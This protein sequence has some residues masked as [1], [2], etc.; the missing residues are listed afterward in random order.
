MI[1]KTI[2]QSTKSF[3]CRQIVSVPYR[4]AWRVANFRHHP[5]LRPF[6]PADFPWCNP[7][8][9]DTNLP[10]DIQFSFGIGFRPGNGHDRFILNTPSQDRSGRIRKSTVETLDNRWNS[11]NWATR[12]N[13][14]DPLV[15]D[16]WNEEEKISLE[17]CTPVPLWWMAQS[18]R[19][20]RVVKLLQ[21]Y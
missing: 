10:G 12:T 2:F 7:W 16:C 8:R 19:K 6:L 1:I 4:Y 5:Q 21:E 20:I 18:G 17:M 15:L 3:E 11:R 9:C 13:R 14:I